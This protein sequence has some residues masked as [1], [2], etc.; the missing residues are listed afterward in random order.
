LT[1]ASF[2]RMMQKVAAIATA[3]ERSLPAMGTAV[4]ER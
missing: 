2:E 4:A 1:F 3:V